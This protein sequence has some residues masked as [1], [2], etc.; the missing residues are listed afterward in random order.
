MLPLARE[1]DL[2]RPDHREITAEAQ[3]P[4]DAADE[5]PVEGV[6]EEAALLMRYE[7]VDHPDYPRL[8]VHDCAGALLSWMTLETV[9]TLTFASLAISLIVAI[10]R[11][12]LFPARNFKRRMPFS[13][14]FVHLPLFDLDGIIVD[15]A[16][17]NFRAWKRI[18]EK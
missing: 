1:V 13:N 3:R 15:T 9:V 8:S 14:A 18:A 4:L 6:L 17:Y 12:H 10:P 16:K 11:A 2:G 7:V 5:G